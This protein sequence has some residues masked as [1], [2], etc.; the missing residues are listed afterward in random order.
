MSQKYGVSL[1]QRGRNI[2]RSRLVLLLERSVSL[3]FSFMEFGT[4]EPPY[5][6]RLSESPQQTV[7]S[8]AAGRWYLRFIH[9]YFNNADRSMR[10]SAGFREP[11]HRDD[12]QSS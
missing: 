11:R 7:A 3:L 5:L 2:L 6:G 4:W 9:P 10:K 8:I 12:S 1:S